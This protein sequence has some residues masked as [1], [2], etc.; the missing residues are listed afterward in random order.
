MRTWRIDG[1]SP[2]SEKVFPPRLAR[3][4]WIRRRAFLGP[5]LAQIPTADQHP[6]PAKPSREARALE[7][8]TARA[9]RMTKV[10][11][12]SLRFVG[13]E[14]DS[15]VSRRIRDSRSARVAPS[16]AL[17]AC[18]P[19]P[20]SSLRVGHIYDKRG[21]GGCSGGRR[22]RDRYR[23]I[24]LAHG[25]GGDSRPPRLRSVAAGVIVVAA[26]SLRPRPSSCPLAAG[27][28]VAQSCCCSRMVRLSCAW[29]AAASFLDHCGVVLNVSRW[30]LGAIHL[31][32]GPPGRARPTSLPAVP[33]AGAGQGGCAGARWAGPPDGAQK[34]LEELG[35][36][37][38]PRR[39]G[40]S[41]CP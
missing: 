2:F 19:S 38:W 14:S 41:R 29:G 31:G 4:G 32:D 10:L 11:T 33:G 21:A 22:N 12:R 30:S 34:A 35:R 24:R 37:E 17:H 13:T 15:W 23:K 6:E 16:M 26:Q 28:G 27:G 36:R 20:A 25:I 3:G 40:E 5:S 18:P 39:N 7:T 8:R 1:E 9:S